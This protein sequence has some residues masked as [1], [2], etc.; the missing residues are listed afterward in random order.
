VSLSNAHGNSPAPRRRFEI[1][2]A[3][4]RSAVANGSRLLDGLDGRSAPARRYRDVAIAIAVD[5]GGYDNLTEAQL[6]LVRSAAG[7]TVLRE[8]LDAKALNGERIDVAEYCRISNSLRRLLATVGLD[9]VPRDVTPPVED[10]V[11]QQAARARVEA[12]E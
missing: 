9:R 7:L 2:P 3:A 8:G 1:G 12:A 11:A 6:Q 10:Y 4:Q 5:L